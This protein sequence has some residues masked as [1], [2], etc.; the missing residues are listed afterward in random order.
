MWLRVA[1]G[2]L[3][4]VILRVVGFR[5]GIVLKNLDIV[6]GQGNWSKGL[7]GKIYR[8]FGL[9]FIE[10]L[11]FPSVKQKADGH[12]ANITGLENLDAVLEKGN[13]ALII[14]AHTGNWEMTVGC[15]ASRGYKVNTIVKHLKDVDNDYLNEKL[16]GL[17]GVKSIFKENAM[18]NIRRALKKNEICLMVIDQRSKKR[19]G[20]VTD[21]FGKETCTYAAPYVISKRF[22]CPVVPAYSYRDENLKDHHA[23]IYPE[24]K[25]I[26][27]QDPD[28][29]ARLNVR[30]YLNTL[31]DFILKYPVQWIWMHERWRESRSSKKRK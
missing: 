3:S 24:V 29:E 26:E 11:Y 2:R 7:V 28:E 30:Q 8:H 14:S 18:L 6:F 17:K 15:L 10:M 9:L 1:L 19:E 20:V 16:R 31:E 4:G 21:H 27:N 25:L 12:I 23:H 5:K 22:K 13:G